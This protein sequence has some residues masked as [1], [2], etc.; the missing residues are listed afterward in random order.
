MGGVGRGG[1]DP[2][3]FDLAAVGKALRA[4]AWSESPLGP[5]R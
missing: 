3:E 5:V 2:A 4:F 1:F